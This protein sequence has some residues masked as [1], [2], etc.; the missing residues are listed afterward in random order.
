MSDL[1]DQPERNTK[2]ARAKHIYRQSRDKQTDKQADRKKER[3]TEWEIGKDKE[4]KMINMSKAYV[5][6]IL[7]A[8]KIHQKTNFHFKNVC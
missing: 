7:K 8:L 1:L 4:Q 5:N 6:N 2:L 3:Q